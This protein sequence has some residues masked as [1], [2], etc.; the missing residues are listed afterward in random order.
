[1]KAFIPEPP[2]DEIDL[3]YALG[4][5][6]HG[7]DMF[8]EAESN[9][10][11]I[12]ELDSSHN[13]KRLLVAL[14]RQKGSFGDSLNLARELGEGEKLEELY[15]IYEALRDSGKKKIGEDVLKE[16]YGINPD[17]KNVKNL[18]GIVSGEEKVE[19]APVDLF[20]EEKEKAKVD[21]PKPEDKDFEEKKVVFL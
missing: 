8:S 15:S 2:K 17:Y 11:R 9:Y 12:L 7:A 13:S 4:K 6:F 14:L 18:L 10:R 1:L 16:I 19:K 21:S 3:R 5:G 20:S